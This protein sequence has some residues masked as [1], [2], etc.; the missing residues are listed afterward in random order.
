MTDALRREFAPEDEVVQGHEH[1]R[2]LSRVIVTPPASPWQQSRAAKLEAQHGAPL[3]PSELIH[4]VRR[5]AGWAPGRPG[6]FAVFYV[7]TAELRAPF[8]ATVDVEGQSVKMAFGSG[9][10]Q[11]QRVQG[12]ARLVMLLTLCGAVLGGGGVLALNARGEASG[13]LEAAEKLAGAKL[14][15]AQAV[16]RQAAQ[17]RAL[18]AALGRGRPIGDLLGD[19][20][21]AAASKASDARL[22]AIH[23]QGGV[24]AVEVRGEQ[25]P[26]AAGDRRLERAPRP[27]R[28]GIWLWGV[29]PRL[30]AGQAGPNSNRAAP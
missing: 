9:G 18:R 15:A 22:A 17:A 29:G 23:W 8:E 20:G 28:P 2:V 26:F 1:P 10:V 7:R 11:P 27:L 6:R 16:R 5:L 21:W 19:L 25:S 12:V 24:M 30:D 13:R 14:A 3:P 4:K